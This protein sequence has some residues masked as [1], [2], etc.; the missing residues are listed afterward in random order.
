MTIKFCPDVIVETKVSFFEA[1]KHKDLNRWVVSSD[2]ELLGH[3]WYTMDSKKEALALC[4][5]L[6][7]AAE[8]EAI[9]KGIAIETIN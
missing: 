7:A 5:Q 4:S 6:N 8:K 1:Y 9:Q 3:H 2:H